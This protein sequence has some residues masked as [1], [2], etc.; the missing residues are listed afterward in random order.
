M[1]KKHWGFDTKDMDTRVR[2][3]DDLYHYANGGWLQKHKMPKEESR[4][5]SFTILRKETDTKLHA[6]VK[7]M[8]KKKRAKTGTAEQLVGDFF[9]SGIDE[10]ARERLGIRPLEPILKKI[11]ITKAE[12]LTR[13]IS[14]LHVLGVHVFWGAGVDQDLK[15][16]ERYALYLSPNMD[17]EGVSK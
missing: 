3:Q 1:T 16:S 5:G 6:I 2:P 7:E 14:E 8:L 11:R 15:D 17:G 9:K 12:D 4:W 13:L 10:A